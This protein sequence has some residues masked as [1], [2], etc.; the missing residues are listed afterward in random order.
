MRIALILLSLTL[1]IALAPP[2]AWAGSIAYIDNGEVWL[3]S[4]D[5][6]QKVRIGVPNVTLAG[7]TD[8]RNAQQAWEGLDVL[9]VQGLGTERDLDRRR[10][11]QFETWR[12]Q[13]R[14]SAQLGHHA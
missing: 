9:V 5:G 1:G 13:L 4:L 12:V 8:R 14:V 7:E 2:A 3:A 11:A 10:T 6:A